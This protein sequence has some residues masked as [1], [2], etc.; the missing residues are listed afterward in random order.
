M[1][2]QTAAMTSEEMQSA[3]AEVERQAQRTDPNAFAVFTAWPNRFTITVHCRR[4]RN[5]YSEGKS[6]REALAAINQQ[7][8]QADPALWEADLA[9]APV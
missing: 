5:L 1:T 4:V 7:L 8:E 2:Q 6:P 9:G 3:I